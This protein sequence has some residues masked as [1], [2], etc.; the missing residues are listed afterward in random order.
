MT[1]GGRSLSDDRLT[2]DDVVRG[3][4]TTGDVI[5]PVAL[6]RCRGSKGRSRVHVACLPSASGVM[7]DRSCPDDSSFCS[8]VD[9]EPGAA[10]KWSGSR[11]TSSSFV[12][13]FFR[14]LS[15]TFAADPVA[16]VLSD[17]EWI[18]SE[19]DQ[20]LGREDCTTEEDERAAA[21]DGAVAAA[22]S[23]IEGCAMTAGDKVF[24][25][26]ACVEQPL[27][28]ATPFG[29]PWRAMAGEMPEVYKKKGM[30]L[31]TNG[32]DDVNDVCGDEEDRGL[33]LPMGEEDSGLCLPMG[34]EV[35]ADVA[36]GVTGSSS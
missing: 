16:D 10:A 5:Q 13:S 32:G 12:R 28:W 14:S 11:D 23:G 21:V 6:P 36:V 9:R 25:K 29:T 2:S 27:P 26:V 24:E 15:L 1:L 4:L 22:P 8:A 33:C 19:M 17:S 35:E 18:I 34:E 31:A 30:R 3:F 7:A 20:I